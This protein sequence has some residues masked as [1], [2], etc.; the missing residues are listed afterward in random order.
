MVRLTD[1]LDRFKNTVWYLPNVSHTSITLSNSAL[2]SVDICHNQLTASTSWVVTYFD[3]ISCVKT[4]S[5]PSA[6]TRP[7]LTYTDQYRPIPT[8]FDLFWQN[9]TYFHLLPPIS[10]YSD[11]W[12][13][14]PT[15]F[16]LRLST[17]F[18]LFRVLPAYTNL[19]RSIPTYTD[20]YRPILTY[21]DL[22]RPIPTY[23]DLFRP[24]STYGDIFQPIPTIP[25]YIP[26]YFNLLRPIFNLFQFISS[27][28][29]P[30]RPIKLCFLASETCI[31]C[32]TLL[33]AF[34]LLRK[35]IFLPILSIINDIR[36]QL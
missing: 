24:I 1:W 13:P 2:R 25:T 10:T 34:N 3:L 17:Y 30:Y 7:I 31:A 32:C 29:D 35:V 28:S 33:Y 16:P 27:Y 22:Y 12:H 11:L 23:T 14:I 5:N 4:E 9:P 19:Y 8:Y 26:T 15:Y 36:N 6:V 21:T 18:N 20:L